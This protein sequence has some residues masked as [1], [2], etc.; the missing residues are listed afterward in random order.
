MTPLDTA[1]GAS[2]LL[3][4]GWLLLLP[5]YLF[6]S[7]L[8]AVANVTIWAF[9]MSRSNEQQTLEARRCCLA[10]RKTPPSPKMQ[11]ERKSTTSHTVNVVLAT[12]GKLGSGKDTA[13]DEFRACL[14]R[15]CRERKIE[16]EWESVAFAKRLKDT[17]AA[18]SGQPLQNTNTIQGKNHYLPVFHSTLGEMLQDVGMVMRWL[19]GPDI[20]VKLALDQPTPTPIQPD[21]DGDASPPPPPPPP[22]TLRIRNITD[23]RFPNEADAI[24]ALPNSLIVRMVKAKEND[25]GEGERKKEREMTIL[26]VC[27]IWCVQKGWRSN[28]RTPQD[29]ARY[30]PHIRNSSRLVCAL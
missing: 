23:C 15:M 14:E 12:S 19:Y 7:C 10:R 11:S 16:F 21:D 4:V 28:G 8:I 18:L 13:S 2:L 26:F 24:L 22:P 30:S 5:E 1:F 9:C 17:V 25:R 27:F 6:V 3:Q 20:W 29:Y